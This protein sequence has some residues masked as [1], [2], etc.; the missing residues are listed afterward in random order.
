MVTK[1]LIKTHYKQGF[2]IIV[3]IDFSNYVN[4]RIFFQLG[5]NRLLHPVIFFSKNSNP[6]E[7][8]YSIYDKKSLAII[9]YFEE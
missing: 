2:T 9:W 1:A 3:E 5:K 6:A 8:K 4:I 7:C